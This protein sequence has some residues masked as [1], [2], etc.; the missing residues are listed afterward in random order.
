LLGALVAGAGAVISSG[1]GEAVA[2]G[3]VALF[4][5][6]AVCAG[7]GRT[8]VAT[9]LGFA[10]MVW[11]A[12]G[13]SAVLGTDPSPTGT[14]LGFGAVGLI[15]AALGLLGGLRAHRR[16]TAPVRAPPSD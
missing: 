5:A 11:T 14:V 15:L 2:L 16:S 1:S 7:A 10:G 13:I 9:A 3:G 6:T 12:A 4:F 8:E